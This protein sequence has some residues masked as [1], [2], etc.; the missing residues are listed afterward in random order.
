MS[1]RED[2]DVHADKPEAKV[3]VEVVGRTLTEVTLALADAAAMLGPDAVI[4]K[5]D[6]S[7]GVISCEY[8]DAETAVG[9]I[10]EN[11]AEE[12]HA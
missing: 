7:R 11:L 12:P 10:A 5:V 8:A 6:E 9:A 4:E 3:T 1:N 2:M